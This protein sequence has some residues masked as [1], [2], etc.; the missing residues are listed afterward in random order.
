MFRVSLSV[1]CSRS[2][3]LG[4]LDL[5]DGPIGCSETSEMSCDHTSSRNPKDW[6]LRLSF[7]TDNEQ[8][9]IFRLILFLCFSS[10][11]EH[12]I[13]ARCLFHTYSLDFDKKKSHC[14]PVK[15]PAPEADHLPPPNVV[16]KNPCSCV[17]TPVC[18]FIERRKNNLSRYL[19][20]NHPRLKYM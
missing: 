5:E 11:E 12:V 7:Y 18:V 16:A 15:R 9:K 19:I 8:C 20:F 3:L 14:P 13:T 1:P 4:A 2:F 6:R 10:L 17:S